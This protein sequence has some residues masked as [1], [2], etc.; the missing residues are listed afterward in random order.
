MLTLPDLPYGYDALEPVLSADTLHAHHDKHHAAY[1]EKAN[2]L[3]KKAGLEKMTLEALIVE[4]RQRKDQPLFNNAAQAWNHGFFW[5]SMTPT[6]AAPGGALKQAIDETFGDLD[7]LKE[8]FVAEG[9]GHFASGWVWLT[10]GERGLEV[11]STHDADDTFTKAAEVPLLTCD[12]WEHAYY[13]DFKQ[14]RPGYLNQWFDK[15]AN[16]SF[17]ERQFAAAKNPQAGYHYPLAA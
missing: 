3:A 1:V 12:L 7:A 2:A 9:A 14:D 4:A 11:I 5:E 15:L 6:R 8:K 10:V 17:A 13:L 16:W